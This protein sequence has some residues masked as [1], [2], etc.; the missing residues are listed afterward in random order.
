MTIVNR[1]KSKKFGFA[2][3]PHGEENMSYR[4][5]FGFRHDRCGSGCDLVLADTLLCQKMMCNGI[6]RNC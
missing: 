2:K 6:L 3:A 1:F 4:I 5:G